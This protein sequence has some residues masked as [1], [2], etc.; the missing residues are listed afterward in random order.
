MKIL[1]IGK[2]GREHAMAWKAAQSERVETVFAAPGSD[3]IAEVA[4]CLPIQETDFDGLVQF[5]K[6]KAIDLTIVGPEQPLVEG[7]VDRFNQ[8]GLE[9]FGP[10]KAAAEIEGSKDFAKSLMKAYGIPTAD[11]ETFTDYEDARAYIKEKGAPI[12]LKADGLAAGKGVIVAMT[13]SEALEGLEDMMAHAK[14]GKA[15]ERV[16]IEEFLA[17]EEF[18]LMALVCGETVVPLDIAQDHKRAFEGDKGPNT[19]GMGAYSPVP[20]IEDAVVKKAVKTILRPAAKAM[21]TENRSFTGILYAGLILTAHGPKVIEFNCRFGDPETQV[22][23]PRL[24]SDL[25]ETILQVMEGKAPDL[26]WS[27]QSAAGIVLASEGYPEAYEKG[28]VINKLDAVD[29]SALVFHA[30]TKRVD[31]DWV[32]AGGR[33]LL[34]AGLADHLKDAS[35]L[36]N[37]EIGKIECQGAFHRRDIAYRALEKS[38][39]N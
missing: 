26:A 5:A 22:I 35:R 14:F 34:V 11:Y 21:V 37:S 1:I 16:V 32:T 2:G 3:G 28:R 33:V 36:A 29:Q 12:V 25:V 13:E 39:Q 19:G 30:G 27:E 31:G 24:Q 17:G 38:T 9:I 20:Y 10:T 8:E 4:E 23:L 6:Q 18:S 7:I 15:G